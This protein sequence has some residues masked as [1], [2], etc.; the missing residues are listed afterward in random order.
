MVCLTENDVNW[1]FYMFLHIVNEAAKYSSLSKLFSVP[2]MKVYG[3]L[4]NALPASTE[5]S[6]YKFMSHS[7]G[8][9]YVYN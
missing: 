2:V 1:N 5:L 3:I 8:V 9:V 6:M 7:A 4:A